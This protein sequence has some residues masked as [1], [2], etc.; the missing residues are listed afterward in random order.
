MYALI[1]ELLKTNA[2]IGTADENEENAK[3]T[4]KLMKMTL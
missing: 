1:S 4:T 3:G 2:S